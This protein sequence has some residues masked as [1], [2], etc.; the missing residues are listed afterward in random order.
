[1][2]K[3]ASVFFM[4]SKQIQPQPGTVSVGLYKIVIVLLVLVF[5]SSP[6]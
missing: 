4:Y 3:D 6:Q 1:M 2:S 5:K